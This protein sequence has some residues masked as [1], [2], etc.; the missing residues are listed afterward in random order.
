MALAKQPRGRYPS[1]ESFSLDITRYLNGFPVS[2]RRDEVRYRARKFI[3]RH[4]IG[5]VAAALV[6]VALIVGS[7]VTW[8]S[9]A[10][11]PRG[12]RQGPEPF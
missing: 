5:V 9:A 3:R 12:A 4:A 7:I 11:G 10:N 6:A 1:A 8:Q 2:P